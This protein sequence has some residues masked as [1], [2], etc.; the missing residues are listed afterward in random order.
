MPGGLFGADSSAETMVPDKPADAESQPADNEEHEAIVHGALAVA[1]RGDQVQGFPNLTHLPNVVDAESDETK[2]HEFEQTAFGTQ[3]RSR[4]NGN[5]SHWLRLLSGRRI[6][7]LR[8]GCVGLR[9]RHGRIR[10]L[11][12]RHR[13]IWLWL[14]WRCHSM[15]SLFSTLR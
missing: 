9:L 11:G 13:H 14:L 15:R 2:Q 8:C 7:L 3:R 1:T 12:L 5:R 10:L 4:R 6:I